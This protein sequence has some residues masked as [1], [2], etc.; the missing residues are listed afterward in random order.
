MCQKRRER[1]QYCTDRDFPSCSTYWICGI[2][3]LQRSCYLVDMVP[4]KRD[5]GSCG[6][7]ERYVTCVKTQ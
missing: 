6:I 1:R 5:P 7:G 4:D 3:E 2:W